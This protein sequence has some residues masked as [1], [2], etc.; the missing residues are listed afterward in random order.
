MGRHGQIRAD[1]VK[2]LTSSSGDAF[3]R[4]TWRYSWY[5]RTK[6]RYKSSLLLSRMST[7][8]ERLVLLVLEPICKRHNPEVM[9]VMAAAVEVHQEGSLRGDRSRRRPRGAIRVTIVGRGGGGSGGGGGGG[10]DLAILAICATLTTIFTWACFLSSSWASCSS[11]LYAVAVSVH[12]GNEGC[13]WAREGSK[14]VSV[15]TGNEG[16]GWAREGSKAATQ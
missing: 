2:G 5:L 14:A 15:H 7:F 10:G 9:K 6:G 11:A 13:G 1:V 4:I 16:C 3:S 8:S 12:T